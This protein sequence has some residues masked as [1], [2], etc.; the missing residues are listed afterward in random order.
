MATLAPVVFFLLPL[1]ILPGVVFYYDV[2]PK[3]AI[4]L[5]ATGTSLFLVREN[6]RGL[7]AL[8]ST[9]SGRL[10]TILLGCQL[11]SLILSTILSTDARLSLGGTNWR[12]YGLITQL[13]LALFALVLAGS[14]TLNPG[15]LARSLR[16]FAWAG[17]IAAVYGILQY[18][19][20]DPLLPPASYHAGEGE[21]T[22]VRPPATLGHAG[23][24][25]TF[26]LYALFAACALWE[27]SRW[28]SRCA[29][30]L[31]PIA[32]LLSG[33]RAALLGLLAGLIALVVL[34][35]PPLRAVAIA[36]VV[37]ISCVGILLVTPAGDRLKARIHWSA[38]DVRGGARLLLWRDSLNMG[39]A[40]WPAG[41][42]LETFGNAFPAWQSRELAR[43]YPDFYHESPHNLFL[44]ALT[45]QG[46][47][48]L[49]VWLG[50]CGLPLAYIR[51]DPALGAGFLA[52]FLSLQFTSLTV[53]TA[54]ALLIFAAALV[55]GRRV[56]VPDLD[57]PRLR[58]VAIGFGL[59]LLLAGVWIVV[60]DQRLQAMK[61]DLDAGRGDEATAAY[62]Q[63]LRCAWPG[64]SADAYY[65]RRIAALGRWPEALA[66][67]RR[68]LTSVEDRQNAF[69]NLATIQAAVNNPAGVEV[70]LKGAVQ[71]APNWFKPHWM[72]ARLYALQG[73]NAE[74]ER[75]ATDAADLAAGRYPEVAETLANIRHSQALIK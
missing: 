49:L 3:V 73:R 71:V 23:Y 12:R 16:A 30:V 65:S 32:I 68:A 11:G 48:G 4:L 21:F 1:L 75:E 36:A 28:L 56:H 69:Y 44:D 57:L 46:L 7:R 20:W 18:A 15:M 26:L 6:G 42:G 40:H 72:L 25:S 19:G 63:A 43:Q 66:A 10:F 8:L 53:P 2:T 47:L 74:A 60:P 37:A 31:I 24:F 5:V 61:T 41:T 33:T 14:F 50:L 62:Q 54:L 9:R 17:C 58:P 52:A 55:R 22:I 29:C 27:K 35:R 70:S 67:G 38:E 51:N 45:A 13:A 34:T 59:A 39:F 64:G